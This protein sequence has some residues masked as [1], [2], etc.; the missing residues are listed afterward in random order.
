MTTLRDIVVAIE[1]RAAGVA[2]WLL[3]R[4][5]AT[6]RLVV[7]AIDMVICIVS[8]W[9]AYSLRMGEWSFA[10]RPVLIV[11]GVALMIFPP[12]FFVTGTY[13]HIFRFAGGRTVLQLGYAASVLT[14]VFVAVFAVVSIPGVPRT[15][16]LLFPIIFFGLLAVSRI[17]MR[18]FLVDMLGSQAMVADAKR[19]LI[20]GAGSAGQQLA[21]SLRRDINFAVLGFIDDD[22]R[23]DKQKL[24]GLSVFHVN[25]IGKTI[26]DLRIDTIFLALPRIS[27][28]RR[29]AIIKELRDYPVHVLALPSINDL[30]S[31]KV[32]INDLREIQIEDLLGRDPVAPNEL[33]LGR[34]I[35]GKTVMVTGAGGSI[36]SELSRQILRL[37]PTRLVLV[38]M[39]EH[40]LY[41]IDRELTDAM[42]AEG[43][44]CELVPELVNVTNRASVRRL[45]ARWQPDTVFH[46]A[47]YKHV[48][49]VEANM[50]SGM[51]NNIVG[52][53]NAALTA[54]EN[55][56]EHFVLIS[57]DKAVR[58]TNIMGAS[59]RICE[60]ILQGLAEEDGRTRFTMVRFGNVLGS[61]GSV[62]PKFQRQIREGGPVTL[63]HRDVT[64][65]F[66][67]IPEAAQLVIQSSALADG[68]EVF[69]LDMGA[70]V[71]IYDLAKT[72]IELAGL[73]VRDEH[74][75]DGDIEVIE[76]G[77]R[78]GEKLYEELLIDDTSEPTRHTRIRRAREKFVS[79]SEL[80][81]QL[82]I[83]M[84]AFDQGDRETARR[85]LRR[86]VPEYRPEERVKTA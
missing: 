79:M 83:L 18:Y 47:A 8:V 51:R 23:L 53:L 57:T 84:A 6:K 80:N 33:L 24:D 63:T 35:V 59:K 15:M 16:A 66:M 74:N 72:M 43:L 46:A 54:R 12:I 31:G 60:L 21:T 14:I 9:V 76:V 29:R 32:S 17:C 25:R 26:S 49:L 11:A 69:L 38:E 71:R 44:E 41:V 39:T 77:L 64:R 50:I 7:L 4:E 20:Y 82:D 45:F 75:P 2:Q 85:I 48:P 36:G 62:V 28:A 40:A 61:S 42:R 1:N 13:R 70:P 37:R 67:T 65:F 55:E 34:T 3:M 10:S 68:G 86:L 81:G 22:R 78:P 56:T 30:A 5:R 52:T 58:P 19:V 73:T 27:R